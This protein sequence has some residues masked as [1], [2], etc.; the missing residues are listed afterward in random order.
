MYFLRIDYK[1]SHGVSRVRSLHDSFASAMSAL[2]RVSKDSILLV[3]LE[4][5]C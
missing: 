3:R 4:Y 2:C 5:C 1:T